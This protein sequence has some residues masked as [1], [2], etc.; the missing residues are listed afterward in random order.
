M[1][2]VIIIKAPRTVL[3]CNKEHLS[4]VLELLKPNA[5]AMVERIEMCENVYDCRQVTPTVI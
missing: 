3:I 5:H 1:Y 2:E 4:R